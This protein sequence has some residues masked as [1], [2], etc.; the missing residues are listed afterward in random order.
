[1]STS[2]ELKL[3]TDDP[4]EIET[5]ITNKYNSMKLARGEREI[6]AADPMSVVL[7]TIAYVFSAISAEI[8]EAYRQNFI[9]YATGSS[10]DLHGKALGTVRLQATKSLCIARFTRVA[11][12]ANAV[13]IPKGTR[14]TA[15]SVIYFQTIE[16][17]EIAAGAES[18]DVIVEA[19]EAGS[20]ANGYKVGSIK[21]IVDN[22]AYLKSVENISESAG[23]TDMES[24]KNYKER[25]F[26]APETFSVAGPKLAYVYHTKS[27]NPDII[28][29]AIKSDE[30]GEVKI[31]PLMK[32]GELPSSE[33]LQAVASKVSANDV[34]PLTDKV[35]VLE[36]V[37]KEYNIDLDYYLY[38]EH[39]VIPDEQVQKIVTDFILWQK[40]VLGRDINPDKLIADLQALGIKRVV[41][42]EPVFTKVESNELALC[43][44][45][46]ASFKGLEIE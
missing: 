22:I 24:D 27:V 9:D 32:N 10:L 38:E 12:T 37:R 45:A 1:M 23:G 33:I 18:V 17:A 6:T 14:V 20:I 15:D 21:Q 35:E 28:D 39:D 31:Y 34:R 36:P 41:I 7:K 16:N 44:S 11:G 43:I 2:D 42:R 3:L 30:P 13:L 5:N 8:N 40:S 46:S 19:I 4:I 25:I 29:V 26:L